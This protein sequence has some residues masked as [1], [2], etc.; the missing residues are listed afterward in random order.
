VNRFTT[1]ELAFVKGR[2]L[3]LAP[4]NLGRPG[5]LSGGACWGGLKRL[6]YRGFRKNRCYRLSLRSDRPRG[7]GWNFSPRRPEMWTLYHHL[8]ELLRHNKQGWPFDCGPT[9]WCV[10]VFKKGNWEIILP[11]P[12]KN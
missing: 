6:G 7:E 9:Y 10:E 3:L 12:K 5:F 1:H 2:G 4:G 11:A 8:G